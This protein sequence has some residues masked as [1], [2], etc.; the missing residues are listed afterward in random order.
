MIQKKMRFIIWIILGFIFISALKVYASD[1]SNGF[2]KEEQEDIISYQMDL[3]NW[4]EIEKLQNKLST[5]TQK[6]KDYD[7]KEEVIEIV[8]GNKQFKIEELIAKVVSLLLGEIHS[9]I[10]LG[11]RFILV[12]LLCSILQS[13]SSSFQ[14]KETNKVA[15]FVCYMVIVYSVIDSI[16]L[17]TNLARDT[18]DQMSEVMYIC[19]PTLLAFMSSSGYVSSSVAMAPVVITAL[20][21]ITY[22]I[23]IFVL[24]CII[25]VLALE[26]V[27]TISDDFKIDKIIQLFYRAIKW[28]LRSIFFV[29]IAILGFYKSTMPYVDKTVQKSALKISSA[30]IPIVGDAVDGAVDFIVNCSLLMKNAFSIAVIVWLVILVSIPLIHMFAFVAVYH[31][32]GAVIEPLGDKKMAQ[33]AVKIAKGGEFIMSCVGMVALLCMSVL[34]ICMSVGSSAV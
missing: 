18:I 14:S 4:E 29:S 17:L 6:E 34:I 16:T 19:M 5:T 1:Y 26:I 13:L 8:K 15:F 21:L 33:I 7:L 31:I 27:G 3:F 32:A 10:K 22:V 24:P 23:K 11:I 25:S 12:V 9:Y 30:F 28:A 2:G 20:N